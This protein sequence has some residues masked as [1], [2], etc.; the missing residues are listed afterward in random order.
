MPGFRQDGALVYFAAFRT[1]LSLFAASA[2]IRKKY[3]K[4]LRGFDTGKG[5]LQFQPEKPIP[6]WLV[7]RIVKMRVAENK[8]RAASR[9][10]R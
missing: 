1:H 3:A 7:A 4:E 5:T 8:S 10:A 2:A 6:A 9:K